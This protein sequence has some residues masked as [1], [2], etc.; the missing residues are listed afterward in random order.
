M[1]LREPV[2]V[3]VAQ[4]SQRED[5]PLAARSPLDLMVDAVSQAALDSGN[6]EILKSTNSIR[7]VR[8]MWGYE[9][10]A[11]SIA[12]KLRL[13]QIETGLTSLGGNYVQTLANQSFLDIQSGHSDII[14]LTGAECGRTQ[15]RARSAGLTL[16][17]NPVSAT[18]GQ[19]PI[20]RAQGITQPDVFIGSHRNTRHQAEL[21]RGIRHPIQYYPLFEIALRSASGE[22][23][24]NHIERIARLWSGFSTVA[25]NNPDAWIQREYSAQEI[26]TV[27]QF[28]RPVSLPYPKLMN[29][30]NSVDQGAAL[31]V[32]SATKAKQLGIPRDRWIYPHASTEAWDHL[33][34]SERD[35]LYSSP[36]IRLAAARLLEL[37][38]LD[39][40]SFDYVDLY[41]C[42]PSAVQIAANEIGLSQNQPLTVTGGLT[43]AGGPWNNYVMHAIAR[44]AILLRSNP[45]ALALVTA[46][47]GLL[48]KHALC[49]YSGTPPQQPFAW[50]SLQKDVDNL[51]R[52]PVKAS[53]EGEAAI[54]TYTVMYEN[55][56]PSVAY[57]A[58][59]LDDGQRT[60][61]NI[62]DTDII[63]S[64]ITSE[65]CGCSG[66]IDANGHFIP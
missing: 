19:D 27:T 38:N 41:S 50:A 9:N 32:T 11:Q 65:F 56:A 52:R 21:Q 42:F 55:Q 17:W 36:A 23:V 46:N 26:A 24:S 33:H 44:T 1:K 25:K 13:T 20:G 37:T 61:A 53:H 30:N 66:K 43:F 35:N 40:R 15:S 45:A 49:I 51:Y 18:P 39:S 54:E 8:G 29:S 3:G 31:I 48:T 60:W 62:L 10:P 57:A 14:V 12:E 4:V 22:T 34:V 58:C 63:A 64:M 5:D 7:V 6:P 2:I 28:N 59:L 16:D 47:G